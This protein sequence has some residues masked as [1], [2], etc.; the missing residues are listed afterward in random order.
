MGARPSHQ[1]LQARSA[2]QLGLDEAACVTGQVEVVFPE[3]APNG[4]GVAEINY[5]G[6]ITFEEKL[7][8]VMVPV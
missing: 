3:V 5:T 8:K 7:S 6:T 2:S 1:G 4:E